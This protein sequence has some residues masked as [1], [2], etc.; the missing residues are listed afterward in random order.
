MDEPSVGGA[1]VNPAAPARRRVTLVDVAARAG[2]SRSTASL[3][4][5]G[6]P[7]VAERTRAAVRAAMDELGYV[8][9][10]GAASLRMARSG[11]VGLVVTDVINPFF[12]EM[13]LGVEAALRGTGQIALLANTFDDPDR[14]RSLLRALLE[15]QPDG[16]LIVPALGTT[17][18]V[19][20]EL[21]RRAVPSVLMTR[22]V[23]RPGPRYVGLDDG[24]AGR[25]AAAHLLD[26]GCARL[27]YFG[28]PGGATARRD[29][30]AGF[31]GPVVAAGAHLDET[32]SASSVTTA[33]GGHALAT[34][35]LAAGGPPPDGIL[36][37]SD[38]I[39]FGLV[40]AL[41]DAGVG[42]PEQVRV[43]GCDDVETARVWEPPLTSIDV[44]AHEMGRAA[45]ALLGQV[46]A[47]TPPDGPRI[48]HPDLVVRSSCGPHPEAGS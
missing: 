27:A 21:D 19:L 35:L 16:L 34:R 43:I 12:A 5:Q 7:M 3:V 6:S 26:H 2:V 30:F 10:R 22:Y 41:R 15:H 36:C 48:L 23:D 17:P 11:S 29:R 44:H 45:V 46:I 14:Q 25:L 20:A 8:Y 24:E 1:P 47:G 39:A 13:T 33:A 18:D 32:W 9:H 42:V 40:R 4:L 31:A 38:T 37:H 28:G